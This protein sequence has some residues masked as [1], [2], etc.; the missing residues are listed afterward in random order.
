MLSAAVVLAAPAWRGPV[1]TLAAVTGILGGIQAGLA[2]LSLDRAVWGESIGLAGLACSAPLVMAAAGQP[3]DGRA[4]SVAALCFSY[5]VSG[6]AYVRT[7]RLRKGGAGFP[8]VAACL[9]VHVA[10]IAVMIALWWKGWLPT[11]G[12]LAWVPVLVR[13]AWGLLRPPASLRTVGWTEMGVS[14]CFLI[15]AVVAYAG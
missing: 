3:L 4:W 15:V 2:L 10:I 9:A 8:A 12:L 13:T 14:I 5:F 7:Y 11:G 1:V 6:L